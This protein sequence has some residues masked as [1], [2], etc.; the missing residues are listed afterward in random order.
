MPNYFIQAITKGGC[1]IYSSRK[2]ESVENLETI[3][4]NE[5]F[6]MY[7]IVENNDK[8]KAL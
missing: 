2:A 3:L 5:G 7:R 6:Q 8:F 1:C 4:K